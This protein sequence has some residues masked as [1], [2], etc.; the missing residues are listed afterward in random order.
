MRGLSEI[1]Q[2]GTTMKKQK[3]EPKPYDES[4]VEEENQYW[5]YD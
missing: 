2:G 5:G 4:N 1:R 3:E